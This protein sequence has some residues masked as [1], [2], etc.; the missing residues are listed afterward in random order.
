[1][2]LIFLWGI[3]TLRLDNVSIGRG[4]SLCKMTAKMTKNGVSEIGGRCVI[5]K[6]CLD[7]VSFLM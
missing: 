6:K 1:M 4:K 5:C 7:R 3:S 2:R